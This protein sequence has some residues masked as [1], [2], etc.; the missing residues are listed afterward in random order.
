MFNSERQTIVDILEG[1]G[2][3]QKKQVK[4]YGNRLCFKVKNFRKDISERLRLI[5]D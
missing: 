4:L 3:I 2:G 5:K 1:F